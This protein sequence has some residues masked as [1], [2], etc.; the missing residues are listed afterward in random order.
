[1]VA[2]LSPEWLAL[3][4][5]AARARGEL[6][7]LSPGQRLVL[8]ADVTGAP[9]APGRPGVPGGPVSYQVEFR[10]AGAR[11]RPGTPEPPD[12]VVT[13]DYETAGGLASGAANAQAALMDGR[14][15]VRGDVDRVG[16]ARELLA[17]LHDLFARVRA[18]TEF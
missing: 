12:L 15:A 11:V 18:V 5:E 1:V 7:N 13:T 14:I 4:D 9:G 6:P 17:E 8:Q 10:P 3:L 2:F 16:A